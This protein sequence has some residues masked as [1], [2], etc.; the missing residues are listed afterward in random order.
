MCARYTIFHAMKEIIDRF[1]AIDVQFESSPRYNVAPTQTAPVIRERDGRRNL[2]GLRWGLV[3]SWA[4]DVSVGQKMINARAETL[5]QKPA[6]KRSLATRR[7]IVPAD[8]FYE[9]TA[10]GKSRQPVRVELNGATLFGIAGLWERWQPAEGDSLYSFTIITVPAN[11]LMERF[12][13]RMPAI[14]KP[15]DEAMWLDREMQDTAAASSLLHPYDPAPMRAFKVD[16]KV[17]RATCDDP[18]CIVPLAAEAPTLGSM[19]E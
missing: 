12:H 7:C 16:K 14:L 5:A 8:G 10:E 6:F 15:Q 11:S 4:P 1:Q 9:W 2:E 3:P 18:S 13:D 17:N 19:F